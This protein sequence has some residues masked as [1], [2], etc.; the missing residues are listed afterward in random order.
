MLFVAVGRNLLIY[1]DVTFKMAAWWPYWIFWFLE[2]KFSLA[3]NIKS[4]LDQHITGV[5]G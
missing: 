3:L 4:K 1:S 2:S 5:Y